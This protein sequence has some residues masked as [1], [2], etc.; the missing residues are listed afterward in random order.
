MDKFGRQGKFGADGSPQRKKISNRRSR[1][2]ESISRNSTQTRN[3]GQCVSHPNAYMT[4]ICQSQ[5]PGLVQPPYTFYPFNTCYD[6]YTDFQTGYPNWFE[7]PC[8]S[9][10]YEEYGEEAEQRC[11]GCGQDN[12]C[13]IGNYCQWEI[14]EMHPNYEYPCCQVE[15]DIYN[16]NG[17]FVFSIDGPIQHTCSEATLTSGYITTMVALSSPDSPIWWG[18]HDQ[19]PQFLATGF[20]YAENIEKRSCN[21]IDNT[22]PTPGPPK[23]TGGFRRGGR[24]NRRR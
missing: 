14:G 3:Y 17:Q 11:N 18:I 6:E 2:I 24:I 4:W 10:T 5:Y 9:I 23:P 16:I 19:I 22:M 12:V 15:A 20:Y 7:K 13:T 1:R 21:V 8:D